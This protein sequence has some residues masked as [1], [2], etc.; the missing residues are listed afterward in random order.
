MEQ[1]KLIQFGKSAFCITI[2]HTW[3]KKNRLKKGDSLFVQESL[4]NSLEIIPPN[5][6]SKVTSEL[7][8][9]ITNKSTDEIVQLLLSTYLNGYTVIILHGLNVG[10]VEFIRKHVHEFIAAEIM[11]VTSNKITIHVFWDVNMIDLPSIIMRIEHITNSIFLETIG[12]IDSEI[13]I[14]DITEKGLEAQRQVLL[15]RRIIK[16]ALNNSA[17]AHKF[18]FSS[19]ELLYISYIIYFF[20]MIEGYITKIAQII[21]DT[22]HNGA[23]DSLKDENSKKEVKILLQ[24]SLDYYKKVLNAYNTH[25]NNVKFV[26]SEYV[27][28]EDHIDQFKKKNP[29]LW[30]LLLA[31]YIKLLIF[32]IKETEFTMISMENA[33]R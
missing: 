11:E 15:A 24:R 29:Q 17:I 4:R 28:F 12:L 22:K 13:N 9:D 31:E 19:L 20:G 25:N 18:K 2:P 21:T 8:I 10:K 6:S 5:S 23:K 14:T 26:F 16:Y 33:P 1:R 3:L 27:D 7:S 30:A 32:K